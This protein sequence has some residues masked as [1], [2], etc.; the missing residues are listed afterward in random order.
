MKR[1]LLSFVMTLVLCLGA[2]LTVVGCGPK[3]PF[4]VWFEGEGGTLVSGKVTQQVI[5]ASELDAPVFEREHYEFIGWDVDLSTIKGN[6]I[7]KAQWRERYFLSF[8]YAPDTTITVYPGEPIGELPEPSQDSQGR[9]FAGWTVD[10][11]RIFENTEWKWSDDKQARAAW[12]APGEYLIELDYDGGFVEEENPL[13]YSTDGSTVYINNPTKPGCDFIGW[14]DLDNPDGALISEIVIQSG[15]VGNKKYVA[16]WEGKQ[17]N[18][19]L[20]ARSGSVSSS[21]KQVKYGEPIGEL[22][23]PVNGTLNFLGWYYDGKKVNETDVC[24]FTERVTL[25]AKYEYVITFQLYSAAT[26]DKIVHVE[27]IGG[28]PADIT[29]DSDYVVNNAF[30]AN[31]KVKLLN[32]DTSQYTFYGWTFNNKKFDGTELA[33]P[34]NTTVEELMISLGN[35]SENEERL[36]KRKVQDSGKITIVAKSRSSYS[37]SH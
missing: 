4:T 9:G 3:T 7:V 24:E 36:L 2:T 10:S 25:L 31:N 17:F 34:T 29:V 8:D 37:G 11:Q 18:I 27:V 16:I 32:V 20:N 26:S 23:V 12:L 19:I 28:T 1:R 13:T 14:K 22:P 35:S 15:S 5:S 30:P 6:T 33:Y 21:K